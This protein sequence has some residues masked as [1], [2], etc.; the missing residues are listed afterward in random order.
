MKK[1]IILCA[2]TL[3]TASAFATVVRTNG[4]AAVV[5]HPAARRAAR[6]NTAR[7]APYVKNGISYACDKYGRYYRVNRTNAVRVTTPA[8]TAVRVHTPATGTVR[9]V[10]PAR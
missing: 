7:C 2:T 1:F 10:R 5:T 4:A 3:I 9:V 6:V 8:G